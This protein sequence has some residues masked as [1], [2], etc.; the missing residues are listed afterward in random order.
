MPAASRRTDGSNPV[1]SSGESANHQ[2]LSGELGS[3]LGRMGPKVRIRF[4]PAVSQ[5]NFQLSWGLISEGADSERSS[6][7]RPPRHRMFVGF[8]VLRTQSLKSWKH[9]EAICAQYVRAGPEFGRLGRHKHVRGGLSPVAL[10]AAGL[11][12]RSA[13]SQRLIAPGNGRRTTAN[14]SRLAAA[15]ERGG[16]KSAPRA[17]GTEWPRAPAVVVSC[18][19]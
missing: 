1:P 4:P 16:G 15:G 14:K 10:R 3:D 11:R 6:A 13:K 12:S 8:F 19:E 5:A 17:R 18:R 9:E 7:D 2:F